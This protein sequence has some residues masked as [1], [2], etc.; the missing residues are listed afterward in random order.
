MNNE[1]P[2][3]DPMLEA[4][5]R[6]AT[7]NGYSGPKTN[8]ALNSFANADE[9]MKRKFNAIGV[10]MA[11]KGGL[12]QKGYA[13]GG[14]STAQLG[15]LSSNL[16]QQT[17]TPVQAQTTP[18]Q[19]SQDQLVAGSAGQTASLQA[20]AVTASTVGTAQQA[21]ATPATPSAAA[22]VQTVSPAVQ[23]QTS[24]TQAA[25]GTVTPQ[26]QVDAQQQTES[27]VSNLQAAQGQAILMDNPVQREIQAGELISGVADAQKAAQFTEQ[28]QAAEATPSKQ[29]TVQGQLEGLMQQF[30]GGETP[31]W[32]AGSMRQATQMLAARGLGASS[33]AGQAVIQATMEAALPIAQIDAATQAQ[34]ESQN[35]SNR[36]QRAMLAAQ[37]RAEFMGMEFNQ[38]FQARVANSSRIGEVANMN[39]TAEQQ[40]AL[41]NSRAANTMELNNLSNRQATVM[42]EAAALA[43]LD[44]ANLSN[45]QQAAVQNAQNFLQM[46]M[47][48]LSNQ[49][50]TNMFR[51]QQNVQALFTDQ[52]ATNA[53]AQFN[54]A[55]ENQTDQFFA[56]LAS[57]TSQFNAAQT[58][59]MAQFDADANNA[60]TEFAAEMQQQRDIFNTQNSLVIAQANAQWRQSIAT[61]NNAADNQTAMEYAKTVN[62]ITANNMDRIWQQERDLLSYTFQ[63]AEGD[64]DRA[65][66]IMAQKIIAASD[67]AVADATIDAEQ[68]KTSGKFLSDVIDALG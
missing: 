64:A 27:A 14:L 66:T 41:E 52:A 18:M 13:V 16:V 62:A 1:S 8:E 4:K 11:N 50:Q 65:T 3:Q 36:Q 44:T 48:N 5:Y 59:A 67:L 38:E 12:M 55:N 42:A 53:A 25:Q 43:N 31:A 15:N 24:A 46:D 19:A 21:T 56:N 68:A 49:Q 29:A 7:M 34:F 30:E 28:V 57:Q 45:R 51:A 54:A 32:A 17:M 39:F 58:N 61:T 60:V 10:A 47:Q 22:Q 40:I 35:L 2:S 26:A 63:T 6:I 20:P 23:A 37:Q 33:M 9:G